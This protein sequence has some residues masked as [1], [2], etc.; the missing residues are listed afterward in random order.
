MT[1]EAEPTEL[2]NFCPIPELPPVRKSSQTKSGTP[3]VH[4]AVVAG[5]TGK[6]PGKGGVISQPSEECIERC[7]KR[8]GVAP[9]VKFDPEK[10]EQCMV[11]SVY[12]QRTTPLLGIQAAFVQ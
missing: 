8:D 2:S 1:E 10:K 9:S 6:T 4:M 3:A 5:M 7:G 12:S 11:C